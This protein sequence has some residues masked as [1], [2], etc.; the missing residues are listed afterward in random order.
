V[1]QDLGFSGVNIN[2]MVMAEDKD[3]RLLLRADVIVDKT[4]SLKEET[5]DERCN[6]IL[7]G[8]KFR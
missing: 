5:S 4:H 8:L 2:A 7:K 1:I 6:E 3:T